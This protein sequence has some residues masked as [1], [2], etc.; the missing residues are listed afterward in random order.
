[1]VRWKVQN[2]IYM[3]SIENPL[4]PAT[5]CK[6]F[7][8]PGDVWKRAVQIFFFSDWENTDESKKKSKMLFQHFGAIINPPG[9][10]FSK[11]E[12]TNESF[13]FV[14]VWCRNGTKAIYRVM[15]SSF[16]SPALIRRSRF[17]SLLFIWWHQNPAGTILAAHFCWRDT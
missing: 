6:Y 14:V 5:H 2:S 3:S 12:V 10:I 4:I 9:V 13:I 1:M 7:S 17:H 16:L 15:C 11:K 8:C